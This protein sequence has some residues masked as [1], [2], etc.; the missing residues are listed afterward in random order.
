MRFADPLPLNSPNAPPTAFATP[1]GLRRI[2][3][4]EPP[5]GWDS[6]LV[7]PVRGVL[8]LVPSL[9]IPC[10]SLCAVRSGYGNHLRGVRSVRKIT[11][12][13]TRNASGLTG[14][15]ISPKVL[16]SMQSNSPTALSSMGPLDC[17]I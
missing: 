2:G 1:P 17:S 12:L 14:R 4:N 5:S 15:G 9:L 16:L 6:K 13:S 7:V 8:P 10:S 11:L 3:E